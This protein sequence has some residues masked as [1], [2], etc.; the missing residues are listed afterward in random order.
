MEAADADGTGRAAG[1]SE[2]SGHQAASS[3]TGAD[4]EG[5]TQEQRNA[6]RDEATNSRVGTELP[7]AETRLKEADSI[8][9]DLDEGQQKTVVAWA[10]CLLVT[11]LLGCWLFMV[12]S[13]LRDALVLG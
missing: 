3:A 5:L 7:A 12:K 11:V 10:A 9:N 8:E 2:G 1:G 4:A 13:T 6:L